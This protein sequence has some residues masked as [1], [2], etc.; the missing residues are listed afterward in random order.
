V[1]FKNNTLSLYCCDALSNYMISHQNPYFMKTLNLIIWAVHQRLIT[2]QEYQF[3][4]AGI[5]S[6]LWRQISCCVTRLPAYGDR[7]L[8]APNSMWTKFP[9]ANQECEQLGESDNMNCKAKTCHIF[10]TNTDRTKSIFF[11]SRDQHL[12]ETSH[13]P[14][15]S[16]EWRPRRALNWPNY[17]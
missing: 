17:W 1:K 3:L 4:L 12:N 16:P 6:K 5:Q 10:I 13:L 15:P 11:N 8:T 14:T 9:N 2:N 7:N